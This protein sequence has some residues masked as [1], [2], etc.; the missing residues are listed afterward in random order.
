MS[1]IYLLG[2][3]VEKKRLSGTVAMQK[4]NEIAGPGNQIRLI[5]NG[6]DL[7]VMKRRLL[8]S[9]FCC[10]EHILAVPAVNGS[11]QSAHTSNR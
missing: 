1:L 2:Y 11:A 6:S 3:G 5:A 7:L 4:T 10:A 8:D 9:R